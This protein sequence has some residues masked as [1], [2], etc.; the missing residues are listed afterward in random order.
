MASYEGKNGIWSVGNFRRDEEQV[1]MRWKCQR[2]AKVVSKCKSWIR[3]ALSR[4]AQLRD[5]FLLLPRW[6]LI[7]RMRIVVWIVDE[8]YST[9]TSSIYWIRWEDAEGAKR[10]QR[11]EKEKDILIRQQKWSCIF[12]SISSWEISQRLDVYHSWEFPFAG[13]RSSQC[14]GIYASSWLQIGQRVTRKLLEE[15][16]PPSN[17]DFTPALNT[18]YS[19]VIPYP[20]VPTSFSL[21]L[22]LSTQRWAK[23]WQWDVAKRKIVKEPTNISFLFGST[24]FSSIFFGLFLLER[25]RLSNSPQLHSP[26]SRPSRP[27]PHHFLRSNPAISSNPFAASTEVI[28]RETSR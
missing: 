17:F 5:P 22:E 6:S 18:P 16:L 14:G 27:L 13:T 10:W 23:R 19:S 24:K 7:H 25:F 12:S 8:L 2:V 15:P 28:E 20:L 3:E 11:V 9:S 1:E 21:S 4:Q 26:A